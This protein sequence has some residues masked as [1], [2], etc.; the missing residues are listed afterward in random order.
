[1]TTTPGRREQQPP[2]QAVSPRRGHLAGRHTEELLVREKAH[3]RE[4]AAIAAA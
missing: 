3:T 4:G 1:M 2:W